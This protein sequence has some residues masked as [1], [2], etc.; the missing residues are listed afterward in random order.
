MKTI[1]SFLT[2]LLLGLFTS[3]KADVSITNVTQSVSSIA[4]ERAILPITRF[5]ITGEECNITK[6]ILKKNGNTTNS[7]FGE[8]LLILEDDNSVRASGMFDEDGEFVF[9]GPFFFTGKKTLTFT[10]ALKLWSNLEAYAGSSVSVSVVD[11]QTSCG[12]VTGTLPITGTTMVFNHSLQIGHMLVSSAEMTNERA[13]IN[14]PNQTLGAFKVHVWSA[15]R[16]LVKGMTFRVN[17]PANGGHGYGIRNIQ[18]FDSNGTVVAGPVDAVSSGEDTSGVIHFND[19]VLF[20]KG[21]ST[22][23]IKGT[24]DTSFNNNSSIQV[25][26]SPSLYGEWGVY[27]LTYGYMFE[28]WPAGSV[29]VGSVS[30]GGPM[31]IAYCDQYAKTV[32]P[33]SPEAEILKVYLSASAY[34]SGEDLR[35]QKVRLAFDSSLA[36]AYLSNIRLFDTNGLSLSDGANITDTATNHFVDITLNNPYLL[37]KDY[38][39]DSWFSIRATVSSNAPVGIGFNINM[40]FDCAR[41][42]NAIG[43]MSGLKAEVY[44]PFML[45]TPIIIG[46]PSTPKINSLGV[47]NETVRVQAT[48]NVGEK[49]RLQ[50]STNLTDWIDT[51]MT[52]TNGVGKVSASAPI[53]QGQAAGFFRLVTY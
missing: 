1:V 12:A 34:R 17:P 35:V 42:I 18:L 4:P 24:L 33:G 28:P 41:N 19:D 25:T 31:L 51:G 37:S 8:V 50:T 23:T 16:V 11:L 5:Q 3:A 47:E 32:A 26:T 52:L 40:D 30:V 38:V 9:K 15:E 10:V 27:G 14:V 22:Y 21:D 43:V 46:T 53:T 29:L 45:G 6:L 2:A 44:V 7:D 13:L 20:P 39:G 36:S 48:G 49:Y